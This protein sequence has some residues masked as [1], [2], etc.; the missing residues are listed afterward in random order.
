MEI[1]FGNISQ[2][3]HS[4]AVGGDYTAE[5]ALDHLSVFQMRSFITNSAAFADSCTSSCAINRDGRSRQLCES[6]P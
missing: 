3:S 5:E 4:D 6:G 1:D 2:L